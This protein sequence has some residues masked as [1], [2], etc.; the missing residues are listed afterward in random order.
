MKKLLSALL[1]L[2]MCMTLLVSCKD[3]EDPEEP[4]D[5]LAPFTDAI[6]ASA[7]ATAKIT[8]KLTYEL[9]SLTGTLNGEYNVTYGADG[10]ATVSYTYEK[11]NEITEDT[12]EFKSTV[13]GT[14]TV[15]AQGNVTGDLGGSVTAATVLKLTLDKEKMTFTVEGGVLTATISAENAVSVL[16]VD[17][18]VEATLKLTVSDG[19]VSSVAITY[20]TAKG[21]A[22]IVAVYTY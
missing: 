7:P 9:D 2:V 4:K 19:K 16:G 3:E 22:E 15:D 5:D 6:T 1:A 13:P 18:G 17:T 10:S 20:T 8:T 11:L 12:T 14:A 21:P